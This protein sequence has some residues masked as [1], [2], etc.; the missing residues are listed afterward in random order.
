MYLVTAI[1]NVYDDTCGVEIAGVFDNYGKAYKA[2][3]IV[4]DWLKKE[5]CE[6]GEVFC[7]NADVNQLNW[8]EIEE[9]L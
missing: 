6:D 5:G 8:H 4:E 2:K 1:Q 9:K 7:F 3:K